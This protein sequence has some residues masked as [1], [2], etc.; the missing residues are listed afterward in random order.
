M[1]LLKLWTETFVVRI[2]YALFAPDRE[3]TTLPGATHAQFESY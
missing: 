3:K 2:F 1:R